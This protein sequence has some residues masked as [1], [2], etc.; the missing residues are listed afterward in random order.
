LVLNGPNFLI[1][2][3][4]TKKLPDP[5]KLAHYSLFH[6]RN[7]FLNLHEILPKTVKT[8]KTKAATAQKKRTEQ[9]K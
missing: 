7:T 5:V 1:C 9:V 4:H 3:S 2:C 6:F 8:L